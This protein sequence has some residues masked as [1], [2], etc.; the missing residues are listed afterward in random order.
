MESAIL[1]AGSL[2]RQDLQTLGPVNKKKGRDNETQMNRIRNEQGA[3]T[4]DTK[5]TQKVIREY[6]KNLY[7]INLERS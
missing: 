2:R 7:S 4:A 6:F 3:I 1:R 5:E